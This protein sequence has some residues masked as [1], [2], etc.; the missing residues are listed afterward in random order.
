MAIFIYTGRTRGG[1]TITGEM[2]AANREAVVARL[3]SSRYRHAIADEAQEDIT[4]PGFG[5]KV[6]EKDIVVFT[7]QFATM[8]DAGL[9]LVQCLEI[10]AA[11][12]ENKTFKKVTDE[13]R[14]PWRRAPRSPTR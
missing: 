2:E 7:R 3:R 11:Q 4:I 10:L 9:P 1:Q 13:I 5:S 8:I 14:Q 6:T 12:Q